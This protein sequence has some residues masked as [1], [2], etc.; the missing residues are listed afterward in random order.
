MPAGPW[1]EYIRSGSE[2]A[3]GV[4]ELVVLSLFFL[5]AL[6]FPSL[7]CSLPFMQM[8]ASLQLLRRRS[9]ELSVFW[10]EGAPRTPAHILSGAMELLLAREYVKSAWCRRPPPGAERG[11]ASFYAAW[12][13]W[14]PPWCRVWAYVL[15][16]CSMY[17]DTFYH[18]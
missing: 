4:L 9:S 2:G 18:I 5:Y 17:T 13:R 16:L 14:R 15:L 8:L 1:A 3:Q 6:R 11:P 7:Y 12:C 10:V